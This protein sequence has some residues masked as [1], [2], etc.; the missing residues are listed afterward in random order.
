MKYRKPQTEQTLHVTN[1]NATRTV[2]KR[3]LKFPN[4]N[5]PLTLLKFD[6]QEIC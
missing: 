6:A 5:L 2:I 4:S 3:A 1:N